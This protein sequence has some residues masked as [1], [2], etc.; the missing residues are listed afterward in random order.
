MK[1]D[2]VLGSGYPKARR[3]IVVLKLDPK[4]NETYESLLQRC[5]QAPHPRLR[6]R[7][8]ALALIASGQPVT[9]VA[10]TLE[11]KRQTIAQW[12]HQFNEQGPG[13]LTPNWGGHSRTT[14]SAQELDQLKQVVQQHP[15][16]VGLKTGS[17]TGKVVAAYIEKQFGVRV[18]LRTALR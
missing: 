15:R 14:L 18:H 13:S 5:L 6:E 17:W 3:W 4:W 9:Q 16:E 1:D 2:I 11:R 7:F 12:V 8:L 10:H